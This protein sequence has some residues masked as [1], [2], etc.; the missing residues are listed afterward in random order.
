MK[1]KIKLQQGAKMPTRAYSHDAAWDLYA[2]SRND[3]H[4]KYLEYDTGV[5]IAIPENH[6]GLVFPRSSV[7][8]KSLLMSNSV[9]VIDPGYCSTIK[10]CFRDFRDP[11]YNVYKV[12]D[13][14]AQLIII[15][16]PV[17]EFEQVDHLPNDG[18]RGHKGF[19]SSGE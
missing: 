15:P 10:V 14:I 19:G 3:N 1:V 13:K 8:D 7:R 11:H 5:S 2:L 16:R 12:G 18:L 9:G 17:I 6:V 4:E